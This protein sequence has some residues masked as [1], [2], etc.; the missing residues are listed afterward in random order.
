MKKLISLAAA[1]AMLV[2]AM[3]AFAADTAQEKALAAVKERIGSTEK[4]DRFSSAVSEGE[5]GDEYS[6]YWS[7]TGGDY[8]SMNI[9]ADGKGR[10]LDYSVYDSDRD[11]ES[12]KRTL[13]SDAAMKKAKAFAD[14][15]NPEL[16]GKY[17]ISKDSDIESLYDGDFYFTLQRMENGIP[18]SGNEGNISVNPSATAVTNYGINYTEGLKFAAADGVIDRAAAEKAY[19]EKLG[20]KLI[21]R[22][23]YDY[24]KGKKTIKPVYV[25]AEERGSYINAVSGEVEK[26]NTPDV[27]MYRNGGANEKSM[28]AAQDA[29]FTE[30]EQTEID[31]VKGLLSR[32]ELESKLKSM[33]YLNIANF[34][35]TYYRVHK[36]TF[37]DNYYANISMEYKRGDEIEYASVELDA[38]T[39]K[40]I[41]ARRYGKELKTDRSEK[42]AAELSKK[43]EEIANYFA[44]DVIGEYKKD[45]T[46]SE[47]G[48]ARY[49][50]YVNGTAVEFDTIDVALDTYTGELDSYRVSYSTE[51]F[52]A[53]DNVIGADAAADKLFAKS[54]YAAT[55][56][57]QMSDEK[58]EK[59]DEFVIVY[60]FDDETP[61][62]IDAVSGDVLNYRGKTYQKRVPAEYTDIDG[63]YAAAAIRA[64]AKYGISLDGDK[65]LPDAAIKQSDLLRLVLITFNHCIFDINDT[66][67]E[68][69]REAKMNGVIKSGEEN[70]D[71]QV[72]REQAAVFI[73]RALG[74]EEYANLEGIY[75]KPF[76]DVNSNVG[77]ISILT[78]MKVFGGDGSGNFNPTDAMTRGDAMIVLNNYLSR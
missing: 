49:T 66:T 47:N 31:N 63:H 3:P 65:F 13:S 6:F 14:K 72:T 51:E 55:Y 40:L 23:Y 9:R 33:K 42:S 24:A 1:A 32:N 39:G 20:M 58:L 41:E 2:S 53:L 54:E 43:T 37:S 17:V 74:I 52:P 71:A 27:I 70:R 28:G 69:Y 19:K 77:A 45:D 36:D 67:D 25:P 61:Q 22:Q 38:K 50:R 26:I 75:V 11:A 12:K 64:L 35:A 16:A 8:A 76:A 62:V 15:L 57:Q 46:A 59:A 7:V 21:Y 10:I 4:Y 78:A 44:A 30:A 68:V 56:M 5:N 18:V 48:Y 34:K 29:A 73:V 60:D